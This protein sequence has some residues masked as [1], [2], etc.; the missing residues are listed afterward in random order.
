MS[1]ANRE[2]PS[3]PTRRSSDLDGLKLEA[4]APEGDLTASQP[5]RL[6][7]KPVVPYV[8]ALVDEIPA[9]V[10]AV[11]DIQV[12]PGRSEEHTS[13]LQSHVNLVCRLLPEKKSG[14]GFT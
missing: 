14:Q 12:P 1:D 8:S 2:L 13:E 4:F 7:V 6:A 3:F 9:G 10:L 5:P 11:V